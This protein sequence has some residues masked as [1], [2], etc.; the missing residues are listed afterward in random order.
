MKIGLDFDGVISD[1]GQLKSNAAKMLYGLDIPACDFKKESIIGGGHMTAAQY[2]AFQDII[3]RTRDAAH[4]M[5]PVD[6]MAESIRRL[7]D[8]GHTLTVVTSRDG[9]GLE[10]AKQWSAEQGL[11]LDFIGVGHGV[12]KAGACAGLDAFVDDDLDK[13][14]QLVGVVPRR[15]LFSWGYNKHLAEEATAK[16]VGSWQEFCEEIASSPRPLRD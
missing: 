12:S 1:C 13:L 3:Y 10:I 16:R 8:D 11:S 14:E 2:A 7:A 9:E 15:F 5:H 6:G 4:F